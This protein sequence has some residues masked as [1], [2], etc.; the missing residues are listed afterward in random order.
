MNLFDRKD[1]VGTF[2]EK[3]LGKINIE[4]IYNQIEEKYTKIYQL[5]YKTKEKYSQIKIE[6]FMKTA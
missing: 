1:T 3:D 5:Y 2:G 6:N 4:S